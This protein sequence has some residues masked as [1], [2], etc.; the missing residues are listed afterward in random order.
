MSQLRVGKLPGACSLF[1]FVI[2]IIQQGSSSLSPAVFRL[3][4]P[5]MKQR[6]HKAPTKAMHPPTPNATARCPCCKLVLGSRVHSARSIVII[7]R[8]VKIPRGDHLH[9]KFSTRG[10]RE[11][12]NDPIRQVAQINSLI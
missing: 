7:G 9:S 11:P 6:K 4:H 2:G 10:S 8:R 5:K 3:F 12:N 1:E